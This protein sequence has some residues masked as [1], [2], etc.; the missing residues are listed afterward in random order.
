MKEDTTLNLKLGS[1]DTY[2]AVSL[3]EN[4]LTDLLTLIADDSNLSIS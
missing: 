1:A 2:K 4:S 3:F